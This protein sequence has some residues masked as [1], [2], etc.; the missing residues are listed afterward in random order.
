[1]PP[2]LLSKMHCPGSAEDAI[3]AT[4]SL[5]CSSGCLLLDFGDISHTAR[6][7]LDSSELCCGCGN[8][9]DSCWRTLFVQPSTLWDGASMLCFGIRWGKRPDTDLLCLLRI[10]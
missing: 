7:R 8:F 2:Q 4:S 1:M 9:S 10:Q 6:G 5:R 3:Y